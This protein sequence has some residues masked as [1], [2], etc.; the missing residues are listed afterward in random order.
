MASCVSHRSAEKKQIQFILKLLFY[1][2]ESAKNFFL[3]VKFVIHCK[4]HCLKLKHSYFKNGWRYS[5]NSKRS[6]F[7]GIKAIFSKI[8]ANIFHQINVYTV[9]KTKKSKNYHILV[10]NKYITKLSTDLNSRSLKELQVNL[11]YKSEKKKILQPL[12]G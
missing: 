8:L 11:S 12:V 2:T 3:R 10:R 6:E 7:R 5:K 1:N 4:A 9:K